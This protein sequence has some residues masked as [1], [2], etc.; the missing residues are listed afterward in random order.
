MLQSAKRH[1]DIVGAL[2][3]REIV[4]RYGREG[5]G[6]LWLIAEP[7]MF[8]LGVIVLWSMLKPA[9]EH[10]IRVAPFCM[11]GY[12]CL[13]LF[14]HTV[15]YSTSALQAN[16]GLLHHRKVRPIHV[17]ISR[18]VM[19]FAGATVAFIVVYLILFCLGMVNAPGDPLK[20]YCGWLILAWLSSAFALVFS[21]LAI[22]Y[23]VIERMLSVFMYLMIPLSGAFIMVDWLPKKY[24]AIYL[25]NPLPHTVEMVRSAVFGEFVKTH[26]NPAYPIAWAM[27]LTLLGLIILSKV[28]D[29]LEIE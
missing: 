23:E 27:V 9:Y 20:L 26:Y 8:C 21:A 1:S 12:M 14:R 4:T 15:S 18:F 2:V 25:L 7:L 19:E 22:R 10:G 24:Q 3:M 17:Y 16:I 28:Q 13:L 11:T 6:F 29:R 5:I